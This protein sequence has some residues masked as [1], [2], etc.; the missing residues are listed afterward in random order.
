MSRFFP[1]ATALILGITG[2]LACHTSPEKKPVGDSTAAVIPAP[3]PNELEYR[4]QQKIE[5]VIYGF[6]EHFDNG[7]LAKCVEFMDDNIRGEI[8]GV[9][10]RGKENW[11]AK[12]DS[13]LLSTRNSHFLSRHL[14][15]NMQFY[16]AVNDTVRVTMY[17]SNL[18]TDLTDGQIQLMSVGYY[19]GKVVKKDGKWLIAVLN[20]L[21][22]SRFVKKF[23][24]DVHG[25]NEEL[26]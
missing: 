15:S 6:C 8:D 5:K 25:G 17:A 18:W 23:Y 26:K 1:I 9:K 12:I 24:Q 11:T 3:D 7:D 4:D 16:P 13:L 20:S 19:K 2:F 22:D 10:L 14:I 21:P